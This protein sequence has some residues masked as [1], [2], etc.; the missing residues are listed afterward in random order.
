M[1]L[2]L[3]QFRGTV[4]TLLTFYWAALFVGT[5]VPASMS[6]VHANDK[7]LHLGAYAG[8]AFLMVWVIA[9]TRPRV[10]TVAASIAVV[11]TYGAVDELSQLLIPGRHGDPWDWF[12]NV[13]GTGFGLLVYF[14]AWTAVQQFRSVSG[15]PA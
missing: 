14:L 2:R 12:A 10:R 1:S 8:L 3:S 9:G 6:R 15:R 11:V 7:L 13:V 4:V 5:H